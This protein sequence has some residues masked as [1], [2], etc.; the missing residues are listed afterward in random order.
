MVSAH[1]KWC[2]L[3]KTGAKCNGHDQAGIL[4][5]TWSFVKWSYTGEGTQDYSKRL[6]NSV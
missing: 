6:A 1:L 5:F 2:S 4:G 3:L